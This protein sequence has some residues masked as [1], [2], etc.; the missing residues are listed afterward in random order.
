MLFQNCGHLKKKILLINQKSR[1]RKFIFHK[2]LILTQGFRSTFFHLYLKNQLRDSNLN[3]KG[4]WHFE[5]SRFLSRNCACIYLRISIRL[6]M[7]TVI[8]GN[9][10]PNF[11]YF[12]M[13]HPYFKNTIATSDIKEKKCF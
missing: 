10:D 13:C 5:R 1:N 9:F 3:L 7:C 6:K 11:L 8:Q 2:C 4:V 12:H